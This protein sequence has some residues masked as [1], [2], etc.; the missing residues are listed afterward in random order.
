LNLN[1]LATKTGNSPIKE[2]AMATTEEQQ[3]KL[4]ALAP[5]R[6]NFETEEEYQEALASFNHRIGPL[7]RPRP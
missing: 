7:L 6:K 3:A 5:E 2:K 4:R 1:T